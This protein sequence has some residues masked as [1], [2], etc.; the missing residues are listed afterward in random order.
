MIAFVI[1]EATG[2]LL[3][4][5]SLKPI[6]NI[7]L[8][9]MFITLVQLFE[10]LVYKRAVSIRL[11][12]I[13]LQANLGL[14]G[15]VF[16]ALVKPWSIYFWICAAVSAYVVLDALTTMHPITLTN[17]L[18]WHMTSAVSW[19]LRASYLLIILFCL[20]TPA[21]RLVFYLFVGMLLMSSCI[22][23]FFTKY[24]PSLWCLTWS[25]LLLFFTPK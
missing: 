24:N 11:L 14:Q 13:L 21:Y 1:G 9:I 10:A 3:A 25:P 17:H 4:K 19:L 22:S 7:G 15:L 6:R 18:R 5:S 12:S 20:L 16:F 23:Y 8:F 2:Y